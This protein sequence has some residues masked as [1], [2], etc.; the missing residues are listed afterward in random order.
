MIDRRSKKE[1]LR[2]ALSSRDPYV[3]ASVLLVPPI[4]DTQGNEPKRTKNEESLQDNGS[5]WSAVL[6]NWLDACEAAQ[7]VSL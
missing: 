2:A 7:A 1:E 4:A 5:D 3:V 6:N